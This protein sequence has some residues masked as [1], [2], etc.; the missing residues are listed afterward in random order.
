MIW[1]LVIGQNKKSLLQVLLK[2]C[3]QQGSLLYWGYLISNHNY[4]P[5][6]KGDQHEVGSS[7]KLY[8]IILNS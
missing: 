6:C 1:E 8:D 5:G 4:L 3:Q 7:E 2:F